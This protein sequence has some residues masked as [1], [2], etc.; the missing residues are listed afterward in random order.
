MLTVC[1]C[2]QRSRQ[3]E[4]KVRRQLHRQQQQ[5]RVNVVTVH[6]RRHDQL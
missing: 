5:Q 2:E 3:A 1:Y 6:Q 4:E